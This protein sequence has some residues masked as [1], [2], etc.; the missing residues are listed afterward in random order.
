MSGLAGILLVV[1]AAVPAAAQ[2]VNVDFVR[3]IVAARGSSR[4]AMIEGSSTVHLFDVSAAEPRRML[5]LGPSVFDKHF[6]DAVVESLHWSADGHFLEL[7]LS[8]GD[9]SGLALV[10]DVACGK[11]SPVAVRAGKHDAATAT[12]SVA[13]HRLY[14]IPAGQDLPA[15]EDGVYVFDP[16]SGK[17]AAL[18]R[19]LDVAGPLEAAEKRLWTRIAVSVGEAVRYRLISIDLDSGAVTRVAP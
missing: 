7:E 3:S 18:A 13:G 19:G 17:T 8:D 10:L 14:A 5:T 15:E 6:E 1:A 12:W 2:A 4:M 16:E 11:E 9:E